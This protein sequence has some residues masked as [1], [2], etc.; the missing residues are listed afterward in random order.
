ML[1]CSGGAE[2]GLSSQLALEAAAEDE[3]E[4][5]DYVEDGKPWWHRFPDFVPLSA[6]KGGRNPRS[7]P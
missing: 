2:K 4:D 5:T 7:E 1:A 3:E 6:L